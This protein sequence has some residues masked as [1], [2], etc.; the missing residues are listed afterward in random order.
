MLINIG[1]ILPSNAIL[2]RLKTSPTFAQ[3]FGIALQKHLRNF[4]KL[5]VGAPFKTICGDVIIVTEKDLNQMPRT[6]IV[7]WDEGSI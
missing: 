7:L 5:N 6:S 2:K 3:D 4:T 1:Y